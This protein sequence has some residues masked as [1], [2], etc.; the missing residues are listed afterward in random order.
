MTKVEKMVT[1]HNRDFTVSEYNDPNVS[2]AEASHP[3]RSVWVAA[4]AGTGKTKVL[5]DRVLRLLL[6]DKANGRMYGTPPHKILCL[7]FTNAAATEMKIRIQDRLGEWAS[8]SDTKLTDELFKLTG[9]NPCQDMLNTARTLFARVL[10]APDGMKIM[11]IHAFCQSV[12]GRFPLEAGISPSFEIMDEG[13]SSGMIEAALDELVTLPGENSPDEVNRAVYS[14]FRNLAR[15]F[16]KNRITK[17]VKT[18]MSE[19]GKLERFFRLNKTD[20]SIKAAVCKISE[21]SVEDLDRD[22]YA[23]FIDDLLK[24]SEQLWDLCRTLEKSSKSNIDLGIALQNWLEQDFE[25]SGAGYRAIQS[26]FTSCKGEKPKKLKTSISKSN[27]DYD[28]YWFETAGKFLRFEE[29]RAGVESAKTTA[30]LLLVS[31][32]VLYAYQDRKTAEGRLDYDDMIL[33][34]RDLLAGQV[35][36]AG[37]GHYIPN[38]PSWVLYKLDGGIDH[39]LVDEA[40]DTNPEQWEI[41]G[42]LT[43]EF[44]SGAGSRDN[45]LRTLFTVG[46]EKQSIYSFQRAD[47]AEFKNRFD[48]YAG[49]SH[50]AGIDFRRVKLNISF[51]STTPVLNLVDSVFSDPEVSEGLRLLPDEVIEHRSHRYQHAGEVSLWPLITGKKDKEDPLWRVPDSVKEVQDASVQLAQAIAGNVR[52]WLDNKVHL[53]SRGREIR[54][55]DIMVLMRT[56]SPFVHTLMK[57][58]KQKN[59]PVSGMDRMKLGEEIAVQDLLVCAEFSFLPGDDLA[60]ATFLKSPLIGVS[61]EELYDMA[62]GRG[63]TLWESVRKNASENITAYLDGLIRTVASSRPYDFFSSLLVRPCPAD[64]GG[65]GMR[66]LKS[67]LGGD[68]EE[69]LEE[70]LSFCL[71]NERKEN[72]SVHEFIHEFRRNQKEIKREPRANPDE[73]QI[74]T[75]HG[76][77]GLQA[78]IVFLP[79]T[80]RSPQEK[81]KKNPDIL[82]V[83]ADQAAYPIWAPGKS[84]QGKVFKEILEEKKTRQEEEYR[85]L[86]YVAMTRA[87]DRLIVC[88]YCRQ[89]SSGFDWYDIVRRGFERLHGKTTANLPFFLPDDDNASRQAL[90][91]RSYQTAQPDG[92]SETAPGEPERIPLPDWIWAKPEKEPSPSRPLSPSRSETQTPPSA[93]PLDFVD[94]ARRFERGRLTHRLLQ[95][96]PGCPHDQ[97]VEKGREFIKM[98]SSLVNDKIGD[99]IL[100]ETL[101]IIDHHEYA[102]IFGPGSQAE[103]PVTGLLKN[104]TP[105]VGQ[106]DR[107]V[108]GEEKIMIIDYKTNRPP[109]QNAEEIPPAYV[110]Q[111]RKYKALLTHIYPDREVKCALIWTLGPVLMPVDV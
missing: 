1:D 109:P 93:G 90:V 68:V 53:E 25:D 71:E 4:S 111:M 46:D 31:S 43:N 54:P 60:L 40:Q 88:G 80:I 6:P 101:K 76:A 11:T 69:I 49:I 17:S 41:I 38:T 36:Q 29:Y 12:L 102:P 24:E 92:Q 51:R 83:H 98:Q 55:G 106:I 52:E 89:S 33:K 10:D 35:I 85:R 70:F 34:T 97:R 15:D 72:V 39:I 44:F 42:A 13:D 8:I 95:F 103:V 96:L 67:R 77:K 63:G 100:Q 104:N 105:V 58:F 7:T 62:A 37:D 47:P 30:D 81:G 19:R 21:V 50:E 91:Y 87:E 86:L 108:V 94:D 57:I 73:V 26:V 9:A 48:H 79:D 65:S 45:I 75:V 99:E 5:T 3:G 78:P 107:L 16:D 61:E 56:R 74:M 23:V 27:P 64:P 22:L 28:D 82:W 59:I 14:A 20:E 84:Y 110:E 18:L 32:Y 2:Q 66:A